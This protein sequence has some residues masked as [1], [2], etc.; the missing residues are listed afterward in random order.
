MK[1]TTLVNVIVIV[2]MLLIIAAC[3]L[4]ADVPKTVTGKSSCGGCTGVVKGCCLLL[5][6][7]DGVRW[8]LRGESEGLK[9]AFEKRHSG[10][11]M[12]ATLAGKPVTKK[13]KDGK[14]YKEVKASEVKIKS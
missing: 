10:K 7:K 9:A 6:D 2:A 11:T 14:D 8:V 4:A 5:T 3:A 1:R 13:G 12:T